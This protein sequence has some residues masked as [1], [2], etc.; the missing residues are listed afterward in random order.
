VLILKDQ[1]VLFGRRKAIHGEGTWGFPG[2]HL[3]H[4]E[5][6]EA[7]ARREV[8]EETGLEIGAI[9]LGTV[10]NDVFEDSGKHYVTLIMVADYVSGEAELLEPEKSEVWQWFDWSAPPEPLFLPI[11]HAIDQ[12]FTPFAV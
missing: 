9:R 10:T 1:S 6:F 3:E 8:L 5:S 11:R 2:G 12:G 7:C 4:S